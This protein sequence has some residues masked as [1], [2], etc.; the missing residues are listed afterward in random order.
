MAV[1]L[2]TSPDLSLPFDGNPLTYEGGW[3]QIAQLWWPDGV[4]PNVLN[5]LLVYGDSSGMNAKV[6]TGVIGI[7][8]HLGKNASEKTLPVGA[9]HATQDRNDLVVARA[10]FGSGGSI[11][12]ESSG[13]KMQLDVIPGTPAASPSDPA[14][15]QNTSQWELVL[16]RL[17]VKS[18]A[19]GG[20][21]IAS[22]D[23]VDLRRYVNSKPGATIQRTTT[24]SIASGGSAA[25]I[26]FGT[27]ASPGNG[28]PIRVAGVDVSN[29]TQAK[30]LVAGRYRAVANVQYEANNAGMRRIYIAKNGT[31]IDRST[32]TQPNCGA[33]RTVA[34]G[35]EVVE[36]LA[37]GDYFT[38]YTFQDSGSALNVVSA[39]LE[40]EYVEPISNWGA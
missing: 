39:S 27:P 12:S 19:N 11:T 40:V 28:A 24:Y 30:A 4:A 32:A 9:P 1:D 15:T 36:D 31:A 8:G 17:L 16:A 33:S 6:K 14:V 13:G 37:V 29:A 25:S 34:L 35:T 22:T 20:G 18:T 3:R 5:E 23:V 21:A 10:V 7:R 38:L 26:P 2:L